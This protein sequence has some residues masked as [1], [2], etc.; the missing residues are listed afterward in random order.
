M[1][2]YKSILTG[3]ALIEIERSRYNYL[4]AIEERYSLVE[5]YLKRNKGYRDITNLKDLLGIPLEEVKE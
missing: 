4:V 3:E 5:N 1:P 2:N